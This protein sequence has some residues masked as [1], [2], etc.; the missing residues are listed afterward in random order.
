[1]AFWFVQLVLWNSPSVDLASCFPILQAGLSRCA[2][3]LPCRSC[4]HKSSRC[5]ALVNA[6]EDLD[7]RVAAIKCLRAWGEKDQSLII[8][9]SLERR[10]LDLVRQAVL[11]VWIC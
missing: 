1:M 10:L 2:G 8:R 9:K 5:L 6:S 4:L 3:R 7:L 11:F